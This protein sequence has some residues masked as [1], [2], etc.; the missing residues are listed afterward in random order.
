MGQQ[1]GVDPLYGTLAVPWVGTMSTYRISVA[2]TGYAM[3]FGPCDIAA[4]PEMYGYKHF[5][6]GVDWSIPLDT[7]I[8]AAADGEVVFA[9][10]DTTG[11]GNLVVLDH[12]VA[13][14]LSGDTLRTYYAHLHSLGVGLGAQV[15]RG[16][17]VGPCDTSGNAFGAHLHFSVLRNGRYVDPLPYLGAGGAA[18][19]APAAQLAPASGTV[20]YE[21]AIY[22]A[23]QAGLPEDQVVTAAALCM[24][25]S[26]LRV[27]AQNPKSG[28]AGLWQILPS[29]HPEYA[30]QKLLH[31]PAYNAVAMVQVSGHG[32]EWHW[33]ESWNYDRLGHYAGPG[34]GFFR[35]YLPDARKA[36]QNLPAGSTP[37][38]TIVAAADAS[39]STLPVYVDTSPQLP[40][41][42]YSVAAVQVQPGA[43]ATIPD[44]EASGLLWIAGQYVPLLS[45]EATLST[46]LQP[47]KF[48]AACSLNWLAEAAGEDLMAELVARHPTQVVLY[49]GYRARGGRFGAEDLV[50]VFTGLLDDTTLDYARMEAQLS[51]PDMSGVLSDPSATLSTLSNAQQ[52]MH[53]HQLVKNLV[54]AHN[55]RGTHGLRVRVETS[56]LVV[57]DVLGEDVVNT[58]QKEQTEWDLLTQLAQADGYVLYAEGSTIRYQRLPRPGAA[59]HVSYRLAG[60][61]SGKG[62]ITAVR[63]Q[64]QPHSKRDYQVQVNSYHSKDGTTLQGQA[65]NT[66]T[67]SI[68][69]LNLPPNTPK[70]TLDAR[71]RSL[72]QAY[73]ATEV[74]L[75]LEITGALPLSPFTPVQLH[76]DV[77]W[78]DYVAPAE[79]YPAGITYH[80]DA[81]KGISMTA[82][83]TNRPFAIQTT[84]Q[85]APVAD[86]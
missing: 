57:G 18:G 56:T 75:H 10:W 72:L 85:A 23:R 45:A 38:G 67:A 60:S 16:T 53:A 2:P 71:A 58:R 32:R 49:L 31:D 39:A 24:A 30:V 37:R 59:Q 77:V 69:T 12:T 62:P 76:S 83:C 84:E 47:G 52:N 1:A 54:L 74:L 3:V 42:R 70:K 11:Y 6:T 40:V 65:G 66:D 86:F 44:A 48:S 26:G 15:K 13:L 20:S 25:E 21:Q 81:Q 63:V 78:R 8:L 64:P 43:L 82:S 79:F 41:Q 28:A 46:F 17:V 5:H 80:F 50:A 34:Q 33:W 14:G 7:E 9:G 73:T 22:Y 4:E 55:A 35:D 27:D 61:A 36:Q 68:I 51:G 29:A 19:A